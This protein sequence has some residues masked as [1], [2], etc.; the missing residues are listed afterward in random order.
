MLDAVNGLKEK[1]NESTDENLDTD[2]GIDGSQQKQGHS[3]LNGAVTGIV[4]ENKK[5][6]DWYK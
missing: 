1:G 5:V 4:K 6:I 3:S 2:I